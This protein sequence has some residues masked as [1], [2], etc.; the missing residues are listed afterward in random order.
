M[1]NFRF[2]IVCNFIQEQE[3]GLPSL[4]FDCVWVHRQVCCDALKYQ[5]LSKVVGINGKSRFDQL[6]TSSSSTP[7]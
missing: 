5:L 2:D 4:R 3:L 1:K 7:P 6:A